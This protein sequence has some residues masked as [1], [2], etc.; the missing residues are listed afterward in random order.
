MLT[1]IGLHVA[2]N[3]LTLFATCISQYAVAAE[4]ESYYM[5]I[6]CP[7]RWAINAPS[8]ILL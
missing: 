8:Y 7:W 3:F 6:A 2:G 4:G 5:F 1:Q